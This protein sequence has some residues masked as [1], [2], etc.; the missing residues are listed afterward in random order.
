M[1]RQSVALVLERHAAQSLVTHLINCYN[2]A[3]KCHTFAQGSATYFAV[4]EVD[5][6]VQSVTKNHWWKLLVCV[7]IVTKI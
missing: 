1:A 2:F 5:V 3:I 6:S 7:Q 4:E